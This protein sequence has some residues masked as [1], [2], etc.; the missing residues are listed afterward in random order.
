MKTVMISLWYKVLQTEYMIY[1]QL[2]IYYFYNFLFFLCHV[3]LVENMYQHF[4]G[5]CKS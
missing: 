1:L 4:R 3:K 2:I 5:L